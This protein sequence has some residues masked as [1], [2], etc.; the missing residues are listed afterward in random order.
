MK[1]T[2]IICSLLTAGIASV[3]AQTNR[4][5]LGIEGGPNLCTFKDQAG[6]DPGLKVF[7]SGGAFFQ[8]NSPKIFSFRTGL[9]YQK[10]GFQQ[11]IKYVSTSGKVYSSTN[12]SSEYHYL[13]LPLLARATFGKKVKFFLNAG[14]YASYLI[15]QKYTSKFAYMP[16]AAENNKEYNGIK[17]WD[18]GA[19]TGVGIAF[20]VKS[21]LISLEVRNYYGFLNTRIPNST[22]EKHFTNTTDLNIG[23][24]YRFGFRDN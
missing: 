17:D 23:I 13:T 11:E 22:K 5:D 8:Y 9:Y 20:P 3:K 24:A 7:F 14:P 1:N 15:T 12:I 4:Y 19:V 10:K 16:V 21:L 18:F 2:L 6:F